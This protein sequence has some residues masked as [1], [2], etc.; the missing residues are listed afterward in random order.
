MYFNRVKEVKDKVSQII[1]NQWIPINVEQNEISN[2]QEGISSF[3]IRIKKPFFD[4][5][6]NKNVFIF[7]DNI[8][9]N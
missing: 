2:S 8:Q 1:Y 9:G 7:I 4:N 3:E 6:K 5:N